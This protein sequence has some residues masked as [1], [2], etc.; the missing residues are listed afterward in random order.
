MIQQTGVDD[1]MVRACSKDLCLV[2]NA[3]NTQPEYQA[4]MRKFSL[5]RF[6][7]V[8]KICT[9]VAQSHHSAESSANTTTA[10]T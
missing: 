10:S 6:M 1:R 7:E 3:A 9:S 2:V 8:S 5:P 4:I